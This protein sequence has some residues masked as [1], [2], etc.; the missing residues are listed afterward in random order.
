MKRTKL[1][2]SAVL[3]IAL[4]YSCKEPAETGQLMKKLDSA[5]ENRD[6]Y[7]A[8]HKHETDSIKSLLNVCKND[9]ETWNIYKKLHLRYTTFSIDSAAHYATKMEKIASRISDKELEFL[10][11]IARI[12]VLH[13][14]FEYEDGRKIFEQLDTTGK[15]INSLAE[16]WAIGTRLYRD[17]IKYQDCSED[18]KDIFFAK[19][20]EL[21]KG[22]SQRGFSISRECRLKTALMYIDKKNWEKAYQILN[23]IEKKIKKTPLKYLLKYDKVKVFEGLSFKFYSID[24]LDTNSDFYLFLKFAIAFFIFI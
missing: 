6:E 16:Y 19:L 17:M 3:V 20:A 11:K 23:N 18:E 2:I 15:S 8:H 1:L 12:A 7:F 4:S 9:E 22:M 10:S 24:E 14:Q 21:R 13:A 5:I